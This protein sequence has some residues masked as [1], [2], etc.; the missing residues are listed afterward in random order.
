[1]LNAEAAKYKLTTTPALPAKCIGCNNDAKGSNLFVDTTSSLDYYGAILFCVECAKEIANLLGFVSEDMVSK[2]TESSIELTQ[3]LEIANQ[4]VEALEDVVRAY[5]LGQ[6]VISGPDS[7]DT[8]DEETSEQ[9]E[10]PVTSVEGSGDSVSEDS[11]PG[12]F[13]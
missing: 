13:E 2:V 11:K 12:L 7:D 10:L 3:Q 5:G 4:K 8:I 6:F 1:M 9:D